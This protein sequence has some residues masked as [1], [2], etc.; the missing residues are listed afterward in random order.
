MDGCLYWCIEDGVLRS[1]AKKNSSRESAATGA[2]RDGTSRLQTPRAGN[3]AE[4]PC[5]SGR[6]TERA[7]ARMRDPE[8]ACRETTREVCERDGAAHREMQIE[9]GSGG[10]GQL[11]VDGWE[12]R[13]MKRG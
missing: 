1:S 8:S 5:W 10:S 3:L 9:R 12:G 6:M 2:A 4:S 7:Q 13:Q 11:R